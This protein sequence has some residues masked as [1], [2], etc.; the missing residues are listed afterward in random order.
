M[1]G[2][3]D[4]RTI[5]RVRTMSTAKK[6]YYFAGLFLFLGYVVSHIPFLLSMPVFADESIYIRWSQLAI[7]D[8]WRYWLFPLNDGKTPLFIWLLVPFQFLGSNQLWSARLVAVIIGWFQ[9][10]LSAALGWELTKSRKISFL[11]GA[12]TAFTPFWYFL[13]RQALMDGLLCVWISLATYAGLRLASATKR[14]LG[15]WLVLGG[16]LGLGLL[17]K[18]PAILAFPSIAIVLIEAEIRELPVA[19]K[20]ATLSWAFT[21]ML[22]YGSAV[23]L[24]LGIFASLKFFP[25]F[26][27]LFHRGGDFLFPLS[28]ILGGAWK[29]T[30]PNGIAYLGYFGA[31]LTWLLVPLGFGAWFS[32]RL[33][34]RARTWTLAAMVFVLP[35]WVLGRVVYP[36][37]LLP[38]LV[39]L[40]PV[41]A[42]GISMLLDRATSARQL[43]AKVLWSGA[44]VWYLATIVVTCFQFIVV[45]WIQPNALPLVAADRQQYLT[46]WS[47]GHGIPEVVAD[48]K[49]T[50]TNQTVAVATEGT[51]GTL[52]DG[53]LL[54][55]HRQNVDN[56]YIEGIGQPIDNLPKS[57]VDR[58]Q[59]FDK[60][61]LVV[62][63]H[64][65]RM[66][67][68]PEWKRAEYCRPYQ[69]P[70]LQVWDLSHRLDQV[71]IE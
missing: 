48:I 24:G 68:P 47:S 25:G 18:I 49:Q 29:Q 8:W 34:L 13:H 51:F 39:F 32:K 7:D 64:R 14:S 37:Y 26:G 10:M 23:G 3:A 70:C 65:L 58:A 21:K 22:W 59:S 27:Q 52:P 17:T 19:E 61:W 20:K 9:V 62:N 42:I 44:V 66:T 69:G 35:I 31:Y 67:L 60:V 41:L 53:I 5:E 15:W 55:F 57:F 1:P 11:A 50:A 54:Y 38:S 40:T 4:S 12:I 71:P 16:S 30:L 2:L 56:I 46:E 6:H 43:L 63:S 45:S 33:G 28:E 36:R